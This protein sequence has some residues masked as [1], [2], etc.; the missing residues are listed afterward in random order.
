MRASPSQPW[1]RAPHSQ[2]HSRKPRNTLHILKRTLALLVL[3]TCC[4]TDSAHAWQ[5]AREQ[6][7]LKLIDGIPAICLP[8]TAWRSFP[9]SHAMLM[10]ID[11]RPPGK[12]NIRLKDGA[13]PVKLRPG[14]CIP[15]GPI[16]VGYER[17]QPGDEETTDLQLRLNTLYYFR[18]TRSIPILWY[19]PTA[20]Y[21]ATFCLKEDADGTF[22]LQK[23]SACSASSR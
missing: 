7:D 21:E 19:M 22:S 11:R 13:K 4:A 2:P 3:G 23:E 20:I 14:K 9:L 10:E 12:W 8:Q 6:A 5:L 15:H 1:M 17:F 18:M 16:P